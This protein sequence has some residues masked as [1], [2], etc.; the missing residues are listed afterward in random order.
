MFKFILCVQNLRKRGIR[1]VKI[2]FQT[3][4][5]YY[6]QSQKCTRVPSEVSTRKSVHIS[7]HSASSR[8]SMQC[9]KCK[10]NTRGSGSPAPAIR[11]DNGQQWVLKTFNHCS[12]FNSREDNGQYAHATIYERDTHGYLISKGARTNMAAAPST[13]GAEMK[14]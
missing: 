14:Q 4:L 1:E 2:N 9:P 8:G 3:R 13:G 7:S 6:Y 11:G 5:N 10:G 12:G